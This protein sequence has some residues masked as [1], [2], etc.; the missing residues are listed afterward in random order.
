MKVHSLHHWLKTTKTHNHVPVLQYAQ[1]PLR[2]LK[3]LNLL[4]YFLFCLGRR[5]NLWMFLSLWS[6][7]IC[8][9]KSL[10]Q[11]L[12]NIFCFLF[13]DPSKLQQ[14]GSKLLVNRKTLKGHGS[15]A[16]LAPASCRTIKL[17]FQAC[18][19]RLTE[20]DWTMS[21]QIISY[22]DVYCLQPTE[23]FSVSTKKYIVTMTQLAP[24]QPRPLP[25]F[26]ILSESL[27]SLEG[28]VTFTMQRPGLLSKFL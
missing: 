23:P 24:H 28:T 16:S 4:V 9:H 22:H 7:A 26:I 2:F 27:Q 14:W 3:L 13:T 20:H 15:D 18:G 5:Q 17:S 12:L 19:L 1:F 10:V 6:N 11:L 25:I 8:G 21:H